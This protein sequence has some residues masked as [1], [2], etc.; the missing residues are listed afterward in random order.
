[1]ATRTLILELPEELVAA[2]GSPEA[3]VSK[4]TEALVIEVLRQGLIGQSRVAELLGVTRWD[5]LDLMGKYGVRDGPRSTEELAQ[6][7]EHAE[8][9]ASA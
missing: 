7:A 9:A 6:D 4:A 1:M 3:T 5:V 8:R 2:F